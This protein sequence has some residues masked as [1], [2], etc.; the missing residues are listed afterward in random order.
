MVQVISYR[1]ALIVLLA[2]VLEGCA[3]NKVYRPVFAPCNMPCEKARDGSEAYSL[4]IQNKNTNSEYLL[5]FVEFDDQGQLRNRRQ[6]RALIEYLSGIAEKEG[7]LINVFVHGW[8]HNAD[9]GS[10]P[11]DE[12]ENIKGFKQILAQ[13]SEDQPQ[14]N[15]R[16]VV[17]VYIGWRGDSIIIP[18]INNFTF[19]DRKNTAQEVGALGVTELL[20]RLEAITHHRNETQTSNKSRLVVIGHS[21][22]GAVVYSATAQILLSRLIESAH[23]QTHEDKSHGHKTN[24]ETQGKV[25]TKH[26]DGFGDLVVLLNPAFEALRYAPAFDMAQEDC[27][28]GI[29]PRLAILTSETDYATGILFQVGRAFNTVFETHNELSRSDCTYPMTLD[30]GEA[31]RNTV[32]HYEPLVSHSLTLFNHQKVSHIYNQSKTKFSWKQQ[33][34]GGQTQFGNTV[35]RHLQ[36]SNPQS[37]FLNIKVSRELMDGH[38]DIFDPDVRKFITSLIEL[39]TVDK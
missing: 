25:D 21:F 6:M 27:K 31:D 16:K 4:Q 28:S 7:V 33:T 32:G 1:L 29:A 10:D 36:K 18:G 11:E 39:S 23:D 9:P 22:G 8:H 13:L 2:F 3:E 20:L 17:G 26:T 34:H 12:D 5:G 14:T 38:N 15:K 19:W 35:L 30:E 24:V 37:P